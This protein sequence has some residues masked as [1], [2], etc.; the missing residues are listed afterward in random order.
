MIFNAEF[1]PSETL[2]IENPPRDLLAALAKEKAEYEAR[3]TIPV[4]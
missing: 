1:D 2:P 3:L 4:P